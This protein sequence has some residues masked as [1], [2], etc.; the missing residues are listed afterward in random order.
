MDGPLSHRK[1]REMMRPSPD[2]L[3]REIRRLDLLFVGH[4]QILNEHIAL[5]LLE[6]KSRL[7]KRRAKI[8]GKLTGRLTTPDR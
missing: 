7:E 5:D 4:M 2:P 8:L 3:Q 1:G 6:Q